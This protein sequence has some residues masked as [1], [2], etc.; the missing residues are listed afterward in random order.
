MTSSAAAR[1]RRYRTRERD[2]LAVLRITI[3]R[4]PLSFALEA[5][6]LLALD[7]LDDRAAVARAVEDLLATWALRVTH[8]P[9]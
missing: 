1:M 9:D 2:G 7:Q 4:E 8:D 3:E 5:A 6:G